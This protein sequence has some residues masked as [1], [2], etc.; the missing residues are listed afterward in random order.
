MLSAYNTYWGKVRKGRKPA[1]SWA[2]NLCIGVPAIFGMRAAGCG[3]RK[4]A[5]RQQGL[6]YNVKQPYAMWHALKGGHTYRV[7]NGFGQNKR[8]MLP[9]YNAKPWRHISKGGLRRMLAYGFLI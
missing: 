2:Y 6:A 7:A 1:P 4:H 9:V 5:W 8:S 3:L